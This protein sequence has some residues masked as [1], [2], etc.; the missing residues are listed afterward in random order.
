[1]WTSWF[2]GFAE[3]SDYSNAEMPDINLPALII[4]SIFAVPYLA[5]LVVLPG[6]RE[7]RLITLAVF[8][9][10][11]L[12]GAVLAISLHFPGWAG[13][14]ARIVAQFRS[15]VNERMRAH[16]GVH[17]GLTNINITLRFEEMVELDRSGSRIDMSQ[18]YYNEKFD[19]SGVSSMTSELHSAYLRGLPYPILSILEYF[20]LNQDSFDWGRHYRTAGHY[21]SAAISF[22]L[23]CWL[24]A[25]VCLLFVPH[26]FGVSMLAT[27]FAALLACLL[28]L[29]MSPCQ[30]EIGFVGT[31]GERVLMKMSFQ[32]AFYCVLASDSRLDDFVS[33]SKC[34][35]QDSFLGRDLQSHNMQVKRQMNTFTPQSITNEWKPPSSAF[36]TRTSYLSSLRSQ[37]SFD[38]VHSESRIPR[39]LSDLSIFQ[40][41][42]KPA[43]FKEDSEFDHSVL[44]F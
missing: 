27:G 18:L 31:Q 13:G 40:N 5:F 20:S 10:V 19:I 26:Q 43:R 12:V 36:H 33:Q 2:G 34:S 44:R 35:Q 1:M 6:V 42:I 11:A 17:V 39:S 30:L 32:W 24:L 41:D 15:H 21:T 8:T 37:S 38:S 22:S 4:S 7:K 28:Y 9:E 25:T 23:A 14:S 3:P 29:I 16:V